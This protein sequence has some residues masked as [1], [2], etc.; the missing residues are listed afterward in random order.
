MARHRLGIVLGSGLLA[1]SV[2]VLV[3]WWSLPPGR[4]TGGHVYEPDQSVM[5]SAWFAGA[6]VE[7][8]GV[9]SFV[10]GEGGAVERR[11]VTRIYDLDKLESVWFVLSPF[12]SWRGPAHAFLSF[13][14]AD[15]QFV[16]VSVE[17]R[18]DMGES[19]NPFLGMLRRYELMY[20]VGDE[21]DVIGL[22]THVWRDPVYLYPTV[23][24]PRQAR[25][26]FVALLERANGLK[27]TPEYYNTLD[28]NCATNLADA[29]NQ[30]RR[31]RLGWTPSLVLPGYSDTWAFDAGLLAIDGPIE[32]TRDRYRID[33]RAEDA[34]GTPAFSWA[35][36]SPES[37][38]H[39]VPPPG[40]SGG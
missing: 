37:L 18:K 9:R 23:A 27:T 30:I 15:S 33:A 29:I 3:V 5:P 6:Q 34:Y 1:A 11:W 8:R 19:Y 22:R 2:V 38:P 24:T 12:A 36:R 31:D 7:V 21:P 35:I 16:S 39:H 4:P 32:A 25:E 14:F 26:L 20:V 40:D 13:Q 10:Y 17:A 28:N